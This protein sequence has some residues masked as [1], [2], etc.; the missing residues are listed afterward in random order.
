[1]VMIL[2]C[3]SEMAEVVCVATSLGSFGIE[4]IDTMLEKHPA[5]SLICAKYLI[6]KILHVKP[7]LFQSMEHSGLLQ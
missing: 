1:M 6:E 7:D 4:K 3:N 5:I 2:G